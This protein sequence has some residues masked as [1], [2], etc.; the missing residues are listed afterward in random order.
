MKNKYNINKIAIT[1][2]TGTIGIAMI[3][4]C[5]RNNIQVIAFVNK[6]SKN[7]N[8]IPQNALIKKVYCS[9]DEMETFDTSNLNAD[10]F[11]HLAWASTNREVRNNFKP[12]ID[13]I[14]YSLDS[15]ELADRLGCKVYIG[16]GSQA[17]YGRKNELLNEE[18]VTNP[19]TAYGMA[20]LCSGQMTRL[21]CKKRGIKHIWPRILSTY[22]PYTQDTTILNYS[23]SCMLKGEVPILT[24]C[25]QV[26][27][28]L[29]VDDAA[30]ALL[31]LVD[32]GE[33]G[34]IYCI[35]SGKSRTLREYLEITKN[36]IDSSLKIN[37]GAVPYRDDSVMHL[38]GDITKIKRDIGFVPSVSFE[39]GIRKTIDWA[40]NYYLK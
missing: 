29:Y 35:S 9:L 21:E 4:E 26:W 23:I 19:Q 5:I 17:E 7:D 33:D 39:D 14:K 22:G 11:V 38:A 13:N 34:E 15:V 18:T 8:R 40:R 25:E 36:N 2:S 28:F 31:M 6:G 20:K 32:K 3:Y 10:A 12:Q 1:G 24:G 37:F 16:A 27:D 30:K